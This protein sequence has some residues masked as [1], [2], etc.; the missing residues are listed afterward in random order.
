MAKQTPILI[1]IGIDGAIYCL[2]LA[3]QDCKKKD[4]ERTLISINNAIELLRKARK[5]H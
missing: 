3:R 2:Q 1:R 5:K 4:I